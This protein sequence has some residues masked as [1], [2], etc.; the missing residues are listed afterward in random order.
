MEHLNKCVI[1]YYQKRIRDRFSTDSNDLSKDSKVNILDFMLEQQE[2]G[3]L[4]EMELMG[5]FRF[6]ALSKFPF[7][8]I[9]FKGNALTILI[10]GF[11]TS[12]TGLTFT[13]YLLA[14]HQHIQTQLR[15]EILRKHT[16]PDNYCHFDENRC[17]LLD[18]VWYESLRLFPPIVTFM[19]RELD[20]QLEQ[21]KLTK[22][23]I[24]ITREMTVQIPIWTIHH[25]A[26]YWPEPLQFNPMRDNLPI[27][28]ATKLNNAFLAFGSG[29][30]NCIGANLANSEAR[31]VLT[32]ILSRYRVELVESDTSSG[33]VDSQ[34]GLL[35]LTCKTVFIHPEQDVFLKFTPITNL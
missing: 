7:N 33:A 12:A 18:R 23:G 16:D 31:A 21:V 6:F 5:M 35:K 2:Q 14:K 13:L 4:S 32:A 9:N 28:G 15:E 34:T 20:D 11:E 10:A 22:S 24:T 8:I 19:T 26:E 3:N 25:N 30:R 27:P 1:E 17:E 29:P